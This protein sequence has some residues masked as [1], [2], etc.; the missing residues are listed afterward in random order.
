MPTL[1]PGFKATLNSPSNLAWGNA[2]TPA[3]I[4]GEPIPIG[5]DITFDIEVMACDRSPTWTAQVS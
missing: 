3:P 2:F 1:R 4:G 5:S